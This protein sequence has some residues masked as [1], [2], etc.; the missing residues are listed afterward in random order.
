MLDEYSEIVHDH[1]V[2]KLTRK[3]FICD[4][5]REQT[6]IKSTD[7]FTYYDVDVTFNDG[8]EWNRHVECC[9]LDCVSAYI[10]RYDG[11]PDLNRC[12]IQK[13]VVTQECYSL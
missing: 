12:R 10:K 8:D 2:H 9:D 7:M 6:Y 3:S 1:P 5:C 4:V 11:D 13:Q